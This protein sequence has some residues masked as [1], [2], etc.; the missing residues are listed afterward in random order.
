MSVIGWEETLPVELWM[1]RETGEVTAVAALPRY[2]WLQALDLG[3]DREPAPLA[4]ILARAVLEKAEAE[5]PRP[6]AEI[7]AEA[8]AFIDAAVAALEGEPESGTVEA[9][10]ASVRGVKASARVVLAYP[11]RDEEEVDEEPDDDDAQEE[12]AD[13]RDREDDA[14]DREDEDGPGVAAA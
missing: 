1:D 6:L 7:A 12:E 10:A 9:G 2:L 14:R 8:G 4:V 11:L 5:C 3:L 13:S